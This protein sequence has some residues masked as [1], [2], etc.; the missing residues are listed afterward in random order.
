MLGI[1]AIQGGHQV[2]HI[3]IKMGLP[4]KSSKRMVCPSWSISIRLKSAGGVVV[5]DAMSA[6]LS[7]WL[8][9]SSTISILGVMSPVASSPR[10]IKPITSVCRPVR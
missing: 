8:S 10:C 2:A 1:S 5:E 3:F 9:A 4:L 7:A 6:W